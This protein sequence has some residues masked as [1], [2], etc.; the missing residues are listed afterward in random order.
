MTFGDGGGGSVSVRTASG[1][2]PAFVERG[3]HRRLP[4]LLT[5]HAPCHRYAFI[6]DDVV[7][8]LYGEPLVAE[9]RAAGLDASLLLFPAGEAHKTRKQWS[10]LTDA[11][12][13]AGMGRDSAV[14][15]VGGGVVGDLAG[16]VAATFLRGV[17]VVQVP[18]SLVAMIDSSIGGK[19]GVDVRAGKNLVGAF[20]PPAAVV[21]DPEA[22]QTLSP[23][24]RAQGLAEA[25]KHGAILDEAYL[26]RLEEQASALLC[27]RATETELAVYRSVELKSGVV[28]RDER[29]AGLREILN[30][31][32]T[33]GHA[34]EAASGYTLRHGD[35]VAAGMVLEA[36]LGEDLG[37]TSAGTSS[38]LQQALTAFGLGEIPAVPGGAAAVLRFLS[39]DKKSRR[40]RPRF[41]LLEGMGKVASGGGWSREVPEKTV[42]ALLAQAM[43]DGG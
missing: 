6:S 10:I 18:T 43:N 23:R 39:A 31:G 20:H 26:L 17:P 30:F 34:M 35:A 7:G 28:A 16:F 22:G 25:L 15:A 4:G 19:T 21:I 33:I 38:R 5:Q 24:E 12:L 1:R 9:A 27:G 11:M 14:V 29:E 40:G 37:V 8:P 13:A 42:E 32:H 36:R 2:Y 41:V 3:I